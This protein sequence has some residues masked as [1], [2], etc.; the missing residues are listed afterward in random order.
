MRRALWSAAICMVLG[1]GAPI[2]KAQENTTEVAAQWNFHRLPDGSILDAVSGRHADVKGTVYPAQSPVG[3]ALEFDGYTG[4]IAA[5]PMSLLDDP[6]NLGISVWIRLE[7]YPWNLVPIVDQ[8]DAGHSFFFGIDAEGHL[9][10][11]LGTSPES[12]VSRTTIP[13]RRWALVT[14]NIE[15]GKVS[16]TIDGVEAP[17]E[18]ATVAATPPD[19]PKG[20]SSLLIG[21]VRTPLLPGLP[22]LIHPQF[23]I[24]YSVA[25]SVGQLTIYRDP[26]PVADAKELFA[27]A[28]PRLLQPLPWPKFPRWQGGPGPFGAYYTTLHFDPVWDQS[29]RI[30]PDSDVVV[31]FDNS[32]IQLI[33]WQ[34]NNYVPAWVTENNRWFTDEFM[35]IYGHP[36]C[37]YGEDCEPMSDKQERYSHVRILESTPARVVVDWRYALSEVE[38]YAIAD[39]GSPTGWGDWA[40]EYWT[41][42][43]DGVAVRRSVLWSTAPERD[44]TEFQESIVLIP[45]GETPTDSLNYDALTFVNMQG[46]TKTYSWQPKTTPE[47]S[48]PHG[49]A[50]FPE[51]KNPVIQWVSLKSQWKPFEVAWG[52]SVTFDSYNNENSISAFEWWNHWPVAQIPS[53]GRPALAADRAGHTSVSHIYWPAYREDAKSVTKILMDGL[54]TLQPAELV[55]LAASWRSPAVLALKSGKEVPYD[56]A[57]R[58]YVMPA[59][60]ASPVTMTLHADRQHPAVD[61]AF[62]APRWRKPASIRVVR[63]GP[64]IGDARIGQVG[65]LEGSYLVVYLPLHATGD[66][67]L[68]LTEK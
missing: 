2:V 1:V 19:S 33:F 48:L 53:S 9:T 55:P 61:L 62:V 28:D 41:V 68:E 34:G 31:R 7:S 56:P 27:R 13:L 32:P 8:L 50:G 46:Q 59:G 49:P 5:A 30:A 42:Y 45:P 54:T 38:Q 21:H 6:T 10:A 36:R 4:E 20:G 57:Q 67:E 40:D 11:K 43:P 51:P 18:P 63:G 24:E 58:A 14:L 17:S 15:A 12:Y 64:V 3:D 23:P 26:L 25:G 52:S 47:L 66:V 60:L 16:F 22:R 44:K 37:P 39:A 65:T 29:R 35:E